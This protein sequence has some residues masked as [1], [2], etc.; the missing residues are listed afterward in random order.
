[1]VHMI[2]GH[3][4]QAEIFSFHLGVCLCGWLM[5]N[6]WFSG[7]WRV[8]RREVVVAVALLHDLCKPPNDSMRWVVFGWSFAERKLILREVKRQAKPYLEL[9]CPISDGISL[10]FSGVLGWEQGGTLSPKTK[11]GCWRY[12]WTLIMKNS[13]GHQKNHQMGA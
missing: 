2:Y 9:G 6:Q 3:I 13:P 11:G 4:Q 5:V 1:M 8:G 12:S 7:H 10:Y